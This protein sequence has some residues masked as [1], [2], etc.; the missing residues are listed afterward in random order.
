MY[1]L[2]RGI[3]CCCFY[4]I[5]FVGFV[6]QQLRTQKLCC[7]LYP[8][9]QIIIIKLSQRSMYSDDM[10]NTRGLVAFFFVTWLFIFLQ[11]RN[12]E[13]SL[14]IRKTSLAF[15]VY[16][17]Q[18]IGRPFMIFPNINKGHGRCFS[19][20]PFGSHTESFYRKKINFRKSVNTAC[21]NWRESASYLQYNSSFTRRTVF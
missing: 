20:H 3:K 15:N 18:F 14:Q 4:S 9:K 1:V 5:I 21:C 13:L 12:V 19:K 6:F 17:L 11:I 2:I 16:C 10:Q 8:S 7:L